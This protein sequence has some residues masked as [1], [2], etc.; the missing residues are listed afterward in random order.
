[1]IS[2][3]AKHR[4]PKLNKVITIVKSPDNRIFRCRRKN[5][6]ISGRWFTSKRRRL[7]HWKHL[8]KRI[9]QPNGSPEKVNHEYSFISGS[10][11]GLENERHKTQN[12]TESM[13]INVRRMR[14]C[15][16]RCDRQ[17]INSTA[18]F[19]VL[20]WGLSVTRYYS[21]LAS[22]ETWKRKVRGCAQ[23]F[24]LNLFVRWSNKTQLKKESLPE[25]KK[26]TNLLAVFCIS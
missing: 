20:S 15:N 19:F 8:C 10:M 26:N 23:C 7:L 18:L 5:Q 9:R 3:V 13:W 11:K 24:R 21:E 6:A 17:V 1:M 22:Y 14:I 2:L 16:C 25:G 4:K 12:N